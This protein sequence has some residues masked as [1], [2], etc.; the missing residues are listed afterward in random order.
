MSDMT[1]QGTQDYGVESG[2]EAGDVNVKA[3]ISGMS[4]IM[5]STLVVM[6]AMYGMFNYLNRQANVA[7]SNVPVALASRIV[8]PEPRLLPEPYTDERKEAIYMGSSTP[9][10]FPWDKRNL[11]I[12]LQYNEA[13]SYAKYKGE[14]G[15]EATRI[16]IARAIELESGSKKPGTPAIMTWQTEH[17]RLIAGEKNETMNLTAGQKQEEVTT[18]DERWVWETPDEK[19]NSESTGGLSLKGGQISR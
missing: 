4:I 19:F 18:F 1:P 14:G 15:R 16:P 13:N 12:V 6:A 2:Y 7:A 17:P 5:A 8:P 11:E 3:V 9:D 10:V